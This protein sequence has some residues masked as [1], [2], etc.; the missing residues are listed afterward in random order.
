MASY[1]LLTYGDI[2]QPRA[3]IAAGETV[4]DLSSVEGLNTAT[5]ILELL[6]QWRTAKPALERFARAPSGPGKPLA[7]LKLL[8]PVLYPGAIY[9]AGANYRDHVDNMARRLNIAPDPDP[10]DLGLSPWHFI[11]S[12]WCV[13]G[14]KASVELNSDFLDWEAELGVVI[15]KRARNVS[16]EDVFEY[17]AGYTIAN[18]LSARDRTLRDQIDFKSPFKYDWIGQKTFDGACPIG[19]W[20]VPASD[21]DDPQNLTVRC[22]VN[23]VVK[24]DSNTCKM[25][26]TTAE[27]IA[28]LSSRITLHPGDVVLTGTPAGVGAESGE[29]LQAGDH[30]RVE[31]EKLGALNTVIV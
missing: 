24:Q 30:V 22:F 28:F 20:I 23:G 4:Y 29:K 15:V 17:V 2:D 14:D 19:P 16:L 8:P 26:F 31:I 13:V 21:I 7:L 12:S 11:K 18:D 27:Q 9:C 10:H 25:L 3:A 6:R 1:R 5:S